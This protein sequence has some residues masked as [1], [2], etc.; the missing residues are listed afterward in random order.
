MKHLFLLFIMVFLLSC[1]LLNGQE[2]VPTQPNIMVM[3]DN[4]GSM[5]SIIAPDCYDPNAAYAGQTGDFYSSG[6][7]LKIVA[8]KYGGYRFYGYDPEVSRSRW[9]DY[10]TD[11][12]GY[13]YVKELNLADKNLSDGL[14]PNQGIYFFVPM[15]IGKSDEIRLPGSLVDFLVFHATPGQVAIWNHF[16]IYGNWDAGQRPVLFKD[17][18]LFD[19]PWPYEPEMA[20]SPATPPA[21]G[22]MDMPDIHNGDTQDPANQDENGY[23]CHDHKIRILAAKKA[24]NT[25]IFEMYEAYESSNDPEME[26]PRIGLT[27]YEEGGNPYGGTLVEPCEYH[28][29]VPYYRSMLRDIEANTWSPMSETYA[30]IWSYF[31][32][33]MGFDIRNLEYFLPLDNPSSRSTYRNPLGYWNRVNAILILSDGVSSRDTYLR[34]LSYMSQEIVF[35]VFDIDL[36]GD[37]DGP[38]DDDDSEILD[39]DGTNY[40]DDLAFYAYQNDLFPDDMMKALDPNWQ[41]EHSEYN[42]MYKDKQFIYTYVVGLSVDNPQLSQTAANGGGDFHS[43]NDYYQ[44]L[45]AFRQSVT[46]IYGKMDLQ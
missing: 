7:S 18:N 39:V 40:L 30:E 6:S 8:S 22:W 10:V 11:V 43:A 3:F 12:P 45:D 15:T 23:D 35:N 44:L 32:H 27:K 2:P 17:G 1:F 25:M 26:P 33:G 34:E 29:P 19:G 46:A 36:W 31:R 13:S 9:G 37:T 16:M 5:N 21:G 20:A 4:S 28:N 14:V 38:G 41:D 24:L 42:M